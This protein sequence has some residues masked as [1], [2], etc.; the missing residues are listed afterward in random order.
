MQG[1]FV[2]VVNE[3]FMKFNFSLLLEAKAYIISN[4]QF[5][6]YFSPIY[7][8]TLVRN[9]SFLAPYINFMPQRKCTYKWEY[10]NF[11]RTMILVNCEFTDYNQLCNYEFQ[12][13]IC[14]HKYKS[15][16]PKATNF[17]T[18]I[19]LNYDSLIHLSILLKCVSDGWAYI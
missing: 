6:S 10:L 13:L 2:A 19:I 15:K 11:I 3:L 8:R 16:F 7:I 4:L 5:F 17:C 14:D 12:S 1:I 18:G 9:V